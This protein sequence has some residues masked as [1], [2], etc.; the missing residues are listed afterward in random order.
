MIYTF[1]IRIY[2]LLILTASCFNTKAKD[3]IRG[4]KHIFATLKNH[5]FNGKT[6]WFHCSSL[7]EF[8]QGRP[9][10]EMIKKQHKNHKILLTFFSPSGYNIRKDYAYADIVT[11]LPLDTPR[12]TEQFIRIVQPA[13]VFFVKYDFWFNMLIRLHKKN[14][15]LY[16]ISGIF[17]EKQI[18]FKPYGRWYKKIL[19]LFDHLFVQDQASGELL[20]KQ[21]LKNV[22]VAGDTRFDRVFEIAQNV[23]K[24]PLIEKF[25]KNKRI[26]IAGSSWEQDEKILIRYINEN[27]DGQLSYIIA[28]HEIN[29]AHIQNIINNLKINVLKYSEANKD[30]VSNFN[31]L[32]ID[33]IGMLSSLY[34]YAEI[35]FIGGGF[36]KGIHNILEAATFGMPVI[37]G[38]N[39]QKFREAHDLMNIK[40]AS[41]IH[42]YDTFKD[43]VSLYLNDHKL[44][45]KA[46]ETA[47]QY[48]KNKKGATLNI[49]QK[50]FQ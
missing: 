44:R 39:Y 50:T 19:F 6:I 11:Y 40:A 48:V 45:E 12:A 27:D 3:W 35:A 29:H 7:G 22:S 36:G 2:Y 15:P 1:T 10:I 46:G 34:Q 49:Y 26:I 47:A 9:L 42:S 20:R 13:M 41:S 38:P 21:G 28:P 37:F 30:N 23:K 31:V 18:F 4:R 16:L 33:N 25:K 8:E 14:I 17:N 5:N 43:V 24:N 32:I